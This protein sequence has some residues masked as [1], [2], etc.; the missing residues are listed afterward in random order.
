MYDM[1]ANLPSVWKKS[2]ASVEDRRS[3][4]QTLA[5]AGVW[6]NIFEKP[7]INLSINGD[8][9]SL[10]ENFKVWFYGDVW[11]VKDKANWGDPVNFSLLYEIEEVRKPLTRALISS[12]IERGDGAVQIENAIELV[13]QYDASN[14]D[15]ALLICVNKIINPPRASI[16]LMGCIERL[17]AH[18][19]DASGDVKSRFM[20][21]IAEDG[22]ESWGDK[23]QKSILHIVRV[24]ECD[25]S[26]SK[27]VD[28]WLNKEAQSLSF[29]GTRY[30]NL[31]RMIGDLIE[32]G[33][34]SA[35]K[36]LSHTEDEAPLYKSARAALEKRALLSKTQK[37]IS[38]AAAVRL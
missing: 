1:V 25:L 32:M 14:L 28:N 33:A 38:R 4:V 29:N 9:V 15:D 35:Q 7:L 24:L 10:S 16:Q 22:N 12:A 3:M 17:K 5:R 6:D 30:E 18:D 34:S 2:G 31:A 36:V 26:K 23:T 13:A 27:I 37:V 21:M 19:A 20:R 8:D 11:S